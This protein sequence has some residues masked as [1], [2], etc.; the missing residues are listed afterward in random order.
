M[1]PPA[2]GSELPSA[3]APDVPDQPAARTAFVLPGGATRGAAQVGMLQALTESE[4]RPDFVVGTS[5]GALNGAVYAQD[6]TLAGL[7]HLAR[8]WVD[9]P[10]SQI[11]P[12]RPRAIAEN[13][14]EHRGYVLDNDGLRDW[15]R[16]HT[17]FARL[18]DLPIPLHA[19]A[20]DLSSGEPVV[21]SH[22]DIVR[23]LLAS[24][25]IPGVFPSIDVDGTRLQDGAA[26]ADTPLVQAVG[27][28]GTE[29]YVL[30]TTPPGQVA[31]TPTFQLLD[32][33]FGHP[34]DAEQFDH[35][36]ALAHVTVH[37]LP[38]PSSDSNPFSFRASRRLI[39]EAYALTRSFLDHTP[40]PIRSPHHS[41]ASWRSRIRFMPSSTRRTPSASRLTTAAG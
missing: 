39:D 15:I 9:A 31:T 18:E 16:S 28:G 32:R 34:A 7:D 41:E 3:V 27:L 2:G 21:L 1:A 12:I 17:R 38:A 22:G 13:V 37:W 19:V 35:I 8:L 24:S 26:S 25:A 14:R 23:A 6:P 33:I 36:A 4:I 30:P 5:A 10:R 29:I 40:L 20:T 11:F